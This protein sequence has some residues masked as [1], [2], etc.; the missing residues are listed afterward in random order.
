MKELIEIQPDQSIKADAGKLRL[1]LVPTALIRAVAHVRHFGVRKYGDSD[2]WM[3]VEPDRYRNALY[4]HLLAYI[5][6]PDGTDEESGLPILW[7]IACNV[8]L[9]IALDTKHKP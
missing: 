6:D 8:A 3:H 1:T 7:H 5:E 9:L 4:R 2:S